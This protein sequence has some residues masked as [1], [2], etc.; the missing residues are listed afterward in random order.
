VR[1]IRWPYRHPKTLRA[2]ADVPHTFGTLLIPLAL[3]LVAGGGFQLERTIA[4]P[5]E[6]DVAA[7]LFGSVALA[8]GLLL[9]LYLLRSLRTAAPSQPSEQSN[10][11][12]SALAQPILPAKKSLPREAPPPQPFHRYYVDAAHISR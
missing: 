4:R 5:L 11:E 10:S 12:E 1:P 6:S 7:I 8:C 2:Q 9:G 3:L